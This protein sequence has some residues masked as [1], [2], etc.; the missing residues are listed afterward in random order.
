MN[1]AKSIS[2]L[3]TSLCLLSCSTPQPQEEMAR[4][5]VPPPEIQRDLPLEQPPQGRVCKLG[6]SC[7]DLDPRPFEI[8]LVSAKHC[9]DKALEPIPATTP[10]TP[11][12]DGPLAVSGR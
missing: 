4:V 1:Q 2:L 9:V 6:T 10:K 7:L 12:P 11:E 3:A 8:C 5:E